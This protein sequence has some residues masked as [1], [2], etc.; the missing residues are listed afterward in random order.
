MKRILTILLALIFIVSSIIF[1]GKII[2]DKQNADAYEKLAES[3][4]VVY[5]PLTEPETEETE[6]ETEATIETQETM[7]ETEEPVENEY[8]VPTGIGNFLTSNPNAVGWI[9]GNA[10]KNEGGYPIMQNVDDNEYYLHRNP[11][12]QKTAAGSIYLDSLHDINADGL[13]TIYGHHM[14]DGSMF[15][16]L[17]KYADPAYMKNQL[18]IYTGEKHWKLTPVYYYTGTADGDYRNVL[19]STSEVNAF[20]K[21]KTGKDIDSAS[22]FVLVTCSYDVA[23]GR[24]YLICTATAE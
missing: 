20:V 15:K 18:D 3:V 14:K 12:G 7:S 17:T 9:T 21:E 4:G 5:E 19:T 2:S 10:L 24:A 23:D 16:G 6:P 1:V 13:H 11:D 8:V 22:V